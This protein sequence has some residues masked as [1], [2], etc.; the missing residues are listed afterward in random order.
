MS[1]DILP[2]NEIAIFALNINLIKMYSSMQIRLM[3]LIMWKD[4]PCSD[5]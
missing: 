4:E 1:P 5:F 3:V 2:V